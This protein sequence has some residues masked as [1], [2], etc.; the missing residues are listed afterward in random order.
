MESERARFR[1][2]AKV[3]LLCVLGCV[4][5]LVPMAWAMHTTDPE[6]GR[7]AWAVGPV[8]G[9]T[10]ILVVLIGAWIRWSREDW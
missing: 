1:F 7:L 6:A 8:L 10:L 9:D 5:G 4:I 3:A 2:G